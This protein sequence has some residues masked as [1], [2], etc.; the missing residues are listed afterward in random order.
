[1]HVSQFVDLTQRRHRDDFFRLKF[2]EDLPGAFLFH[3]LLEE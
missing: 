1:M 3:I 2:S